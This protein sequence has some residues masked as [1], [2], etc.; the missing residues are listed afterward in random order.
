MMTSNVRRWIA[1]DNLGYAH[2]AS[3]IHSPGD[4]CCRVVIHLSEG[5]NGREYFGWESNGLPHLLMR[6]FER[7]PRAA[8]MDMSGGIHA[9]N[10]GSPPVTKAVVDG[11]RSGPFSLAD[12][13]DPRS[14]LNDIRHGHPAGTV[15]VH[16]HRADP[17]DRSATLFRV[18]PLTLHMGRVR[19]VFLEEDEASDAPVF[20]DRTRDLPFNRNEARARHEVRRLRDRNDFLRY[21]AGPR[22]MTSSRP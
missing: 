21:S 1:A 5:E 4:G 7:L 12:I 22:F 10:Q 20:S 17:P 2:R 16:L 3:E 15:A 19:D 9:M 18:W 11:H 14:L 8:I 13:N 6:Q